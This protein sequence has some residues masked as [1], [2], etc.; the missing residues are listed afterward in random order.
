M[1]V[2]GLALFVP[3]AFLFVQVI[4]ASPSVGDADTTA[5]RPTVAVLVPAHDEAAGIHAMLVSVLAQLVPGDRCIVV[6][7]NCSDD[8]ASIARAAGAEVVERVDPTHRGKGFA[9][10]FGL[11][12]M[13][14]A[15]PEV[16]VMIDA[17]CQIGANGIGRLAARA[18][19]LDRPVQ[20]LYLMQAPSD[21][22]SGAL[23]AE[24][25]WRVKNHVRPLGIDRLGLPCQLMGS[26]MA[27]PWHVLRT[28]AIAS[29]HIVEDMK[30]GIDLAARGTAAR[31][32]PDVLVLSSFP[33][34]GEGTRTQRARWEHG[35]LSMMFSAVPRMLGQALRRRD[36]ALLALAIDLTIPPLALLVMLVVMC[37]AISLVVGLV[38]GAYSPFVVGALDLALVTIAVG[39]S[40]WRYGRARLPLTVLALAPWYA[41]AKIPLYA[42]FLVARETEWIR[43]KRDAP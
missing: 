28:V 25:A 15:P 32:C 39:R 23:I 31:F 41:I 10:D 1:L 36:G 4:A 26:G 33:T 5:R 18:V 21:A 14:A 43:S 37:T 20:A 16:V 19:V 40:W 11:R 38:T 12:A 27:F 17:D 22:T 35:H 30:L 3:C 9:L 7:D 42:R 6:A 24:F 34:Q 8:T 2:I 13:D 29:G